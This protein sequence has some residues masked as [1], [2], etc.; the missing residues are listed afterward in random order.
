MGVSWGKLRFCLLHVTLVAGGLQR[1]IE[2]LDVMNYASRFA[3]RNG[4]SFFAYSGSFLLTVELLYL[5]LTILAFLLTARVFFSLNGGSFF[6]YSWS[7]LLT[8]VKCV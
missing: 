5:Q 8:V 7:F 1:L 4:C 3:I 2:I 6:T